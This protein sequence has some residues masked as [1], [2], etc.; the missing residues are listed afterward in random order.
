MLK[1]G[2]EI[3]IDIRHAPLRSIKCVIPKARTAV[4][5]GALNGSGGQHAPH[6]SIEELEAAVLAYVEHHNAE[7][8]P[9]RWT[10]S[11]DQILAAVGRFCERTLAAQ[12]GAM[13]ATSGAAY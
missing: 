7:P 1:T 5:G 12:A 8:R 3:R 6:R 13:Q 10:K 4:Q 9:F 2:W 11:A